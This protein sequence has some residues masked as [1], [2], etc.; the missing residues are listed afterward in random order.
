MAVDG[1]LLRESAAF[2]P[3]HGEPEPPVGMPRL[4]SLRPAGLVPST[5]IQAESYSRD[6]SAAPRLIQH[7]NE[8]FWFYRYLSQVYDHIVNPGHW[9]EVSPPRI[10]WT[11]SESVAHDKIRAVNA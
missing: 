4:P 2:F 11:A 6:F 1:S 7:K 10:S 8:A 5:R 9:T 3:D